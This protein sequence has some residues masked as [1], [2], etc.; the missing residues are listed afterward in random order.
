MIFGQNLA[1]LNPCCAFV[2]LAAHEQRN[3]VLTRAGAHHIET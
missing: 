3:H 2:Q 1:G